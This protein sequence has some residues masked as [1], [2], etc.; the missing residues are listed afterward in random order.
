MVGFACKTHLAHI[1]E[2]QL[3]VDHIGVIN[4]VHLSRD[5][6]HVV[7]LEATDDLSKYNMN[8]E[9]GQNIHSTYITMQMDEPY[10]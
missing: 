7:V 1:G 9:S 4:G 3:Q 5:V 6:D 8:F 10:V 2:D